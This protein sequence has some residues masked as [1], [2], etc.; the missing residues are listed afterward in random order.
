MGEYNPTVGKAQVR[1]ARSEDMARESHAEPSEPTP[2]AVREQF[3]DIIGYGED[4]T[5][6]GA[7]EAVTPF[8][9]LLTPSARAVILDVLVGA[10]RA[11]LT[12]AEIVDGTPGVSTSSFHRHIQV[13]TDAG[14][15]R[16]AGKKGNAQTYTLAT[17]HPVAQVLMMLSSLTASGTTHDYL[18]ERFVRDP[19][20]GNL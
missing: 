4:T 19:D 14:V 9:A 1:S 17:D 12:V 10:P 13:L 8:R 6:E 5:V 16:T 15:V 11:E 3:R 20:G 18:D 7:S 2:D